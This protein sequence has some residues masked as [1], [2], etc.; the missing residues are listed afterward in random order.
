MNVTWATFRAAC[1]SR[2]EQA[3]ENNFHDRI[4]LHPGAIPNVAAPA[5]VELREVRT[6]HTLAIYVSIRGLT[7]LHQGTYAKDTEKKEREKLVC[8]PV[9]SLN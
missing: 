3:Y 9:L 4:R 7:Q 2:C 6:I 8:M 1:E 5:I